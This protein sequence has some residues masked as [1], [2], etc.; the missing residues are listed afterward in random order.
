M[1]PTKQCIS[2]TKG[3]V[4]IVS[5]SRAITIGTPKEDI[6]VKGNHGENEPFLI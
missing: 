3:N 6:V 2:N 5:I 4:S 1:Y